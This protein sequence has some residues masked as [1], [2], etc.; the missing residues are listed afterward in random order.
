[1]RTPK[2][3]CP[4]CNKTNWILGDKQQ[5]KSIEAPQEDLLNEIASSIIQNRGPDF[6]RFWEGKT[7][8]VRTITCAS[9]GLTFVK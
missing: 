2:D 1:M 6:E 7:K 9:C 3:P 5:V 8:T 4:Q